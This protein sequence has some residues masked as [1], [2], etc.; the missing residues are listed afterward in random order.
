VVV[1][2]DNAEAI[3]LAELADLN[4]G[5]ARTS[6]RRWTTGVAV[7]QPRHGRPFKVERQYRKHVGKK[8]EVVLADGRLLEGMLEHYHDAHGHRIQH[9]SKVKG[10]L[11]K[12]GRRGH[13][14]SPAAEIRDHQ[15]NITFN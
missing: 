13:H 14:H 1:E 2:V 7:Q 5:R 9:P 3:T 11:P 4:K 8:V 10:R 6:A 15:S 12:L